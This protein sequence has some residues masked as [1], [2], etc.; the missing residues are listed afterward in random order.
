MY[1]VLRNDK[2]SEQRDPH[3]WR[4]LTVLWSRNW[5]G[6]FVS[7]QDGETPLFSASQKGHLS[8]VAALLEHGAIVEAAN[9]VHPQ[10]RDSA[11]T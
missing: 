8:V 7:L 1:L 5:P 4:C 3:A 2:A 11:G 6:G 9:K 10:R